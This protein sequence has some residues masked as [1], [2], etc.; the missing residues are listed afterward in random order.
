MCVRVLKIGTFCPSP[1]SLSP[2]ISMSKLAA[3]AVLHLL[4]LAFFYPRYTAA[5]PIS[6]GRSASQMTHHTIHCCLPNTFIRSVDSF[7]CISSSPA[8]KRAGPVLAALAKM[9]TTTTKTTTRRGQPEKTTQPVLW[10]PFPCP[11]EQ[12]RER[13]VGRCTHLLLIDSIRLVAKIRSR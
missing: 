8:G 11:A 12:E 13:E 1:L 7:R 5:R 10:V 9:T 3:A 2:L 4:L 6:E